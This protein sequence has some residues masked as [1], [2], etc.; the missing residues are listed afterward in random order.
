MGVTYDSATGIVAYQSWYPT[1]R[2]LCKMGIPTMIT[3]FCE[4][5]TRLAREAAIEMLNELH[6]EQCVSEVM[7]NP[8][9]NPMS[10]QGDDNLLPSYSNCFLFWLWPPARL[11]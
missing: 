8:F 9:R 4:E 2:L 6:L 1:M 5:A 3:D 10:C 11:Q 7:L